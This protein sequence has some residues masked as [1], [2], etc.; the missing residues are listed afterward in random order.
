MSKG[1]EKGI[2]NQN[3]QN[4][5]DKTWPIHILNLSVFC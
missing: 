5:D 1:D 3:N 2:K 4:N